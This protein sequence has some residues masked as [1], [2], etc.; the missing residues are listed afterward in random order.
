MRGKNVLSILIVDDENPARDE[1]TYLLSL[2]NE[3]EIVGEADSGAAAIGLAAQLKPNVIFMDVQMRGMNGLETAVVLRTIIPDTLLVFATAYD[4]YAVQA[5]EVGAVDYLLKPFESGR[6]HMTVERLKSYHSDE[7]GAAVQR[8]DAALHKAKVVVQKLPLEKNGKIIMVHYNDLIY[9]YTQKG[10]VTV[11]T[12]YGEYGYVG[13][14][15]ELEDRLI[16]TALVRV[17][18]SYIVNLDKVK[19]VVPWFKGTYWLKVEGDIEIPVSKSKVK[20]IKGIL[21]LK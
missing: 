7:W 11:V 20:E 13:T 5:F 14:L 18:K 4:E 1:L 15:T 12:I 16:Q 3:V 10:M 17:H 8:V 2:E 9:V 6:I 19:E 21:G